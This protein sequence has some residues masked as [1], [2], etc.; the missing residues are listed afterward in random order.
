V[1]CNRLKNATRYSSFGKLAHCGFTKLRDCNRVV[2]NME[3][4]DKRESDIPDT[5]LT[6]YPMFYVRNHC[7]TLRFYSYLILRVPRNAVLWCVVYLRK[8]RRR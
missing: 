5:Q 4:S 6:Y 7:Q 8:T 3:D 2:N 1:D